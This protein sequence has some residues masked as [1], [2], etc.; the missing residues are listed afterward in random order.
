MQGRT[1]PKV[2][3]N[4]K[5]YDER[6]QSHHQLSLDWTLATPS[7]RYTEPPQAGFTGCRWERWARRSSHVSAS[8]G[9]DYLSSS[10]SDAA[11]WPAWHCA[12]LETNSNDSGKSPLTCANT[13]STTCLDSLGLGP[14]MTTA[15]PRFA[16]APAVT[17]TM[18]KSIISVSSTTRCAILRIANISRIVG[19]LDTLRP[20]P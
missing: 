17:G 13:C 20:G 14:I 4:G 16:M 11:D 9:A 1:A 15:N 7:A 8:S 18:L 12:T 6:N 19:L 10:K 2:K 5:K 3:W